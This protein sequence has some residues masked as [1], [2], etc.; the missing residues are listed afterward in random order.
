MEEVAVGKETMLETTKIKLPII[1][2]NYLNKSLAKKQ[3]KVV[4]ET[5][6]KSKLLFI[7]T[8]R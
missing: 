5:T 1:S 3:I 6:G 2:R 8:I 7:P 4:K